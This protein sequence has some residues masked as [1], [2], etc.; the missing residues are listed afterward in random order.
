MDKSTFAEG[1]KALQEFHNK[2]LTP[3]QRDILWS[4]LSWIHPR[5]WEAGLDELTTKERYWP[6]PE[7]IIK[8]CTTAKE[9]RLTREKNQ[10]TTLTK[11][12]MPGQRNQ[13]L[14][15]D[16]VA[17]IE[18]IMGMPSGPD[19][20]KFEIK[21]ARAMAEKYPHLADQYREHELDAKKRLS[22]Y[23]NPIP[24]GNHEANAG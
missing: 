22:Q 10:E 7:T 24:G 20:A 5:D 17:F 1:M 3:T 4:K 19:K 8:H 14:A 13:G 12:E 9:R 23:Q 18:T 15:K 2:N 16:S 11:G 21:W 6:T